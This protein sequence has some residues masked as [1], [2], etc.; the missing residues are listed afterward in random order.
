M[1]KTWTARELEALLGI[2]NVDGGRERAE[3]ALRRLRGDISP[4]PPGVL[5]TGDE[6]AEAPYI[7]DLLKSAWELGFSEIAMTTGGERL[8]RDRGYL[9][10][11]VDSHLHTA[12]MSY[13]PGEEAL[14]TLKEAISNFRRIRMAPDPT[15][16]RFQPPCL[17]TLLVV[18][19]NTTSPESVVKN[20]L[21]FSLENQDVV[22]GVLFVSR[23]GG[24]EARRLVEGALGL[25][26]E[27][28]I[29]PQ[30]LIHLF[31][32]TSILKGAPCPSRLPPTEYL[33]GTILVSDGES[34]S[35][36]TRIIQWWRLR[37]DVEKLLEE[38]GGVP[39]TAFRARLGGIK[40]KNRLR[41][42]IN[43]GDLPAGMDGRLFLEI[44][45]DIIQHPG[46][47]T[48][49]DLLWHCLVIGILDLSVEVPPE[50]CPAVTLD[51]E[52]NI[53]PVCGDADTYLK[54]VIE[55]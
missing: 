4:P 14:Q 46:K 24:R 34:Y 29:G 18:N 12:V 42:Y 15:F 11:L 52:H 45:W 1:L 23:G 40:L 47:G 8:S 17:S 41:G 51:E 36:L 38:S 5:F 10:L 30:D 16:R 48:V 31:R 7:I 2:V 35:P 21:S 6:P 54:E 26:G 37:E 55:C 27:E 3:N 39:L 25:K 32:L 43:W 20:A 33:C 44:L 9:Q 50:K 13:S 28:L 49:A 19:L 22:R 53:I